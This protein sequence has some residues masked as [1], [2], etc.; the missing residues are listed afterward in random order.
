MASNTENNVLKLIPATLPRSKEQKIKQ[1]AHQVVTQ[2]WINV[3]PQCKVFNGRGTIY[4]LGK[5]IIDEIVKK[6]QEL[7]TIL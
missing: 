3:N 2:Q 7:K 1:F 6:F 5:K 4:K